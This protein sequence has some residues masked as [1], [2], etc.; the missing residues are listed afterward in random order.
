M[1][2]KL[3]AII[4]PTAIGKTRLAIQ[5]AVSVNGEIINA[6]SRQIYR[7]YGYRHRQTN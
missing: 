2:N 4:G 7:I 1:M 5:L 3:M 6:D